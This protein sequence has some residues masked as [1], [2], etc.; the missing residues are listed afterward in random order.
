MQLTFDPLKYQYPST[1]RV[2]YGRRG[3]VCTTQPL[4]AQ[5]GLDMIKQ[6]GNA[7]DAAVATAIAMTVLEPTSNGIGSDA[8]ALVWTKDGRISGLNGSGFAPALATVSEFRSRGFEEVPPYGLLPVTVSGAPSTWSELSSKYGHLPFEKLFEPA[9]RYAEEGYPVQSATAYFWNRAFHL[10]QEKLTGEE[11][12]SWFDT[13]APG[14]QAPS[15][16]ELFRSPDHGRTLR[17]LAA[18]HCESFYRGPI[19]DQI[20]AFSRRYD[21]LIRKEDLAAFRAEW[22]TPIH[23][24]YRG[25]DVWE[26]PPNGHG[27]TALMALNIVEGFDF[28]VRDHADTFHRQMEA[29]KL[30]FSDGKRYIA[31]P[32]AMEV[33]CEQLLSKD[34]AA[35][36]RALIGNEARMPEAGNPNCGGTIYLCTAD[37]EG[38]MV[39]YIQSNFRGFGSG[40]VIPGTG[41]SLQ[42]RGNQFTM[43]ETS[44]NC[45]APGKRPYHTI[46]PGFLSKDGQAVGPFGVMGGMMQPQGHLQVLMNTIDFHLNPQQALD[47]PRWQWMSGKEIQV[48]RSFPWDIVE[49]LMRRGHKITMAPDSTPFGRGEIIWRDENGVLMGATESRADGYVAAW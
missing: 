3:M 17:E 13:F 15:P 33:S 26:M 10:Y 48:E 9:I 40:I 23:T 46:I 27:I 45:I 36:R 19:A 37:G 12:K 6:G 18:T 2:V 49:E 34:Y 28:T 16:G 31:D 43:D 25:Y 8:F 41:I 20:D 22:V 42:D 32:I 30:A 11:F 1:R 5:A 24:D 21:G 14:G 39:S 4:A 38:N 7:V 44:P 47:A 29:M 35:K